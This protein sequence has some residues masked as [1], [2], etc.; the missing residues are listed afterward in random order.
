MNLLPVGS[1]VK[2]NIIRPEAKDTLFVITKRF[3]SNPSNKKEYF[4]YELLLYPGGSGDGK[5]IF[6]NNEQIESLVHKGYSDNKD[7]S[8]Q[9]LMQGVIE[10]NNLRKVHIE[11]KV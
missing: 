8:Y 6:V 5:N 11:R 9:E 7:D 2:L 4:E 10:K 3:V 1:V